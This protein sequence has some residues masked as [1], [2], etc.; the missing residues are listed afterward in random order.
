M[1]AIIEGR[2]AV[3]EALRSG[4]PVSRVLV[5]EGLRPDS[6]LQEIERSA[7]ER[8]VPIER[9]RRKTL[10]DLSE[11]GAHQGVIA[12]A[13]ELRFTPLDSIVASARGE[14]AS[15][16]IALDH[17][18]DPG[19]L[20]AIARSAEVVGAHGLVVP[21]RR[22]AAFSAGAYKAA[23]GALSWLPIAQVPNLV[24]ALA[25]CKDAGYWIVGASE[26]AEQTAWEAPLE[27]R[28]VLVLGAEDAGLTRLVRERCDLL[29]GLPVVGHVGSLNV[30]QA[31]TV[32]AYEWL[33]RNRR[34]A[35]P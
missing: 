20:G 21:S 31:G 6:T 27:G 2:N 17:I 25:A 24:R 7:H 18:T 19:N 35:A 12:R 32:L 30:A 33:R 4:M 34:S 28:I 5:A 8:A 3:L 23:A 22:S 14:S 1:G 26:H 11:R 13:G 15:L 16:L 9:V 29:V 10:D